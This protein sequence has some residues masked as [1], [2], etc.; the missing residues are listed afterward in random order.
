ML[1][2]SFVSKYDVFVAFEIEFKQKWT[3]TT[4]VECGCV[5]HILN[6]YSAF[7]IN[8]VRPPVAND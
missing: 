3:V 1:W 2:R 6:N 4:T 8:L 5:V 7:F